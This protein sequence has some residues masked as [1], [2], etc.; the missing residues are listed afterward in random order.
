MTS[1]MQLINAFHVEIDR[2]LKLQDED[3]KLMEFTGLFQSYDVGAGGQTNLAQAVARLAQAVAT[4][5]VRYWSDDDY[6][7]ACAKGFITPEILREFKRTQPVPH[8]DFN[9]KQLT[10]ILGTDQTILAYPELP[11]H[12]PVYYPRDSNW[13]TRNINW[14]YFKDRTMLFSSDSEIWTKFSTKLPIDF[15]LQRP[16]Y[17]FQWHSVI[18]RSDFNPTPE[19]WLDIKPKI[20]PKDLQL[21]TNLNKYNIELI[22]DNL[23]LGWDL[24]KLVST[25][26]ITLKYLHKLFN[27]KWFNKSI[28][29][30][31]YSNQS[32]TNINA[33]LTNFKRKA[34]LSTI[35]A[36]PDALKY[37][38]RL[39][40]YLF[41][42][43]PHIEKIVLGFATG[44][45]VS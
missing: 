44:F 25:R 17:K 6:K 45:L 9:W 3:V 5:P 26:V 8:P 27:P 38:C 43:R 15:I 19:Q 12:T 20:N 31:S 13:V 23:E 2:K 16:N 22:M 39:A 28:L 29:D 41:G 37:R 14:E 35:S 18:T 7:Y 36:E 24:Q 4:R 40:N 33:A 10:I 30:S 11:W 1:N 42:D 34:I 32:E 21:N